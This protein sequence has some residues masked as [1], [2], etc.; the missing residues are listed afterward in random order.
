MNIF[1]KL[2]NYTKFHEVNSFW[3]S[4]PPITE[5][6]KIIKD[7][8]WSSNDTIISTNSVNYIYEF[9][10]E[11]WVFNE[12]P[13]LEP[14]PWNVDKWRISWWHDHS[15]SKAENEGPNLT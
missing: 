11:G 9:T 1:F 10:N 15:K 3:E 6:R 2:V 12:L 14:V 7:Y 13:P 4:L 8:G 5:V